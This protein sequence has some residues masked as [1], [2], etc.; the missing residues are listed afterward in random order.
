M[1]STPT[2][3]LAMAIFLAL[4]QGARADDDGSLPPPPRAMPPGEEMTWYLTLVVNGQ[5]SQE[6]V[7]VIQRRGH[8][9]VEAG[10]LSRHRI[11]LPASVKS[12]LVDV[13]LL[14]EV[15]SRY[16]QITQTLQLTVPDDWL[17][18]QTLLDDAA[19]LNYQIATST[20]G[21][22]LNYDA[23]AQQ[24]SGRNSNRYVAT[25]LEQRFFTGSSYLSN[26]GTLRQSSGQDYGGENGYLRFD[27]FWRYSDDEK[28]ISYQI[29]DVITNALSWSNAVRLG[30]IRISRNFSLR[31]DL[32]TWPVFNY[33][34]SAAV[35][36]SVDLFINGFKASSHDINAGPFT[37]INTPFINGSGEA[38]VVT[39]DALGRQVSTTVP[40]YVANTLLREGLSDF[41]FSLGALR[42]DYAIRSNRYDSGAFS[43]IWR[44][45]VNNYVTFSSHSELSNNLALGGIGTDIA[46]WRLGTFS[47]AITVSRNQDGEFNGSGSQYTLGYSWLGPRFS[48]SLQHQQRSG[49]YR[50]LSVLNSDA[51]LSKRSEQATLTATPFGARF[52]SFSVGYFDLT[53]PD[54]SRTRLANF[55]WSIGVWG[56]SSVALSMNK[57]LGDDGYSAQLQLT[58]PFASDNTFTASDQR[59]VDGDHSQRMTLSRSAPTQGGL[60]YNLAWSHGG[61]RYRQ[62]D[63]TWRADFATLQAGMYA[64]NHD[65]TRW[66]EV[67]GSLIWMDNSLHATDKINDA[68]ILVSTDNYPGVP[69]RYENQLI[70]TT[71]RSGHVLVPWVTSWYPAHLSIDTLGLPANIEVDKAEKRV[72]VREGSGALVRFPL[73]KTLTATLRLLDNHRQ[74]LPP[75]SLVHDQISGQQAVVGYD[76]VAWLSKLSRDNDLRVQLP[77]GRRCRLHFNLPSSPESLAS[78]GSQVCP[79]ENT[80]SAP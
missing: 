37:L 50:D 11:H 78:L 73:H 26:T 55:S 54:D 8:Y 24:S 68:F 29:G 4:A 23:Y 40:F 39:T 14:P 62:A 47:N 2:R 76:G 75:G 67:S 43:G 36:G 28:L 30:G 18:R 22:L 41:D 45:G 48:V 16:D 27:T 65:T 52:G 58:V 59:N 32:V 1:Y 60:G 46:L 35:P 64:D 3:W 61:D 69:V 77:D 17:P 21:L 74:P 70:G 56:N 57:T 19:R 7:P 80:E 15:K 31:P 79:L 38:T 5:R 72:A 44:Y 34:G 33:Q 42:R 71:N 51:R 20:P 63:V 25:W 53:S 9:W 12:G 10:A 66:G 13:N 49:E 6:V